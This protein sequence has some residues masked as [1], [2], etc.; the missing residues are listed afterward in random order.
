MHSEATSTVVARVRNDEKV[1][2][3]T[4][5]LGGNGTVREERMC[6]CRSVTMRRPSGKC[7]ETDAM[8]SN[9][10]KTVRKWMKK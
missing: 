4:H 7:E 9:A 8:P 6:G 2:G 10:P 5:R 3:K 1:S